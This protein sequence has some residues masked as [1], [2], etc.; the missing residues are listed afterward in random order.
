MSAGLSTFI[1]TALWALPIIVA[2]IFVS[3]YYRPP[4]ADELTKADEV[5]KKQ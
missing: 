2:L 4:S 3:I 5:A 1:V